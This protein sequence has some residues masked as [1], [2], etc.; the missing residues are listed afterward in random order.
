MKVNDPKGKGER[1]EAALIAALLR[2][3][4]DVL[5]PFGD[6]LRYDMVI[7]RAGKFYRI[8][9]KAGRLKGN[10]V[11]FEPS[12]THVTNT[13][14]RS[15]HQGYRGQVEFIGVYCP[16]NDQC[17]LVDPNA[18]PVKGARLRLRQGK[19]DPRNFR[20]AED[21][22]LTHVLQALPPTNPVDDSTTVA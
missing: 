16:Q 8:Q 6:N 20:F 11:E 4:E 9:C 10:Y 3:G 19:I 17:Y 14:K 21:H 1:C 13:G 7:D 12:S 18:I 15:R 5:K 22:E 2:A